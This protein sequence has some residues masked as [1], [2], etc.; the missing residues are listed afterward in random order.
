MLKNENLIS[1]SI[2]GY[3]KDVLYLYNVKECSAM[4]YSFFFMYI[5]P[6]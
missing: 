3:L 6:K 2:P 5:R 1:R 4:L